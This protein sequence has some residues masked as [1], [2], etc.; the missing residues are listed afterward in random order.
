MLR[1]GH[2]GEKLPA[3]KDADAAGGRG[4]GG[5]LLVFALDL[6]A[7]AAQARVDGGQ[8]VFRHRSFGQRQQLR[9]VQADLRALRLGIEFADGFDLV[10][11]ELDAHGAV[12]LQASRHRECRRG[13]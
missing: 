12:G 9:F 13:G 1:A 7:L 10:A 8:Q 11:E 5:H 2:G 6:D 4:F 3:G